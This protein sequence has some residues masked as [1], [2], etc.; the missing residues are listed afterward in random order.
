MKKMEV[1]FFRTVRITL[2]ISVVSLHHAWIDF[3]VRLHLY[4]LVELPM[5][6]DTVSELEVSIKLSN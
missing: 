3:T 6:R 1:V 4:F 5:K 2:R